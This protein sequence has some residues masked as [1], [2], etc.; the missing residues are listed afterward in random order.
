MFWDATGTLGLLVVQQLLLVMTPAVLDC[1]PLLPKSLVTW[2]LV[3]SVV[4]R[5]DGD[6]SREPSFLVSGKP[7]K[8]AVEACSHYYDYIGTKDV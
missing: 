2:L 4:L 1:W 3:S 5:M 7:V 6:S 8:W